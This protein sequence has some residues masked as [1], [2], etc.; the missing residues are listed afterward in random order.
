M[1]NLLFKSVSETL[2]ELAK[3]KKYL[4]ADIGITTILHTWGQNLMYDPHIH[5]IVPSGGLSNLGNKWTSSKDNFF[6]PVEVLSRKF[7]GKILFYFKKAFKNQKFKLNKNTMEF[8]NN[9]LYKDFIN[10]MYLKEWVVY[11]KAPYKNASRT[12]V[13][14]KIYS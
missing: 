4:D 2:L 14:R 7:R 9:L 10:E 5:C 12:A 8:N 11:S 13:F 3:D 6:I 1:Y